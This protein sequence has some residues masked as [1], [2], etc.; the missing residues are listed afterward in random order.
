MFGS[1]FLDFLK[2]GTSFGCDSFILNSFIKSSKDD[3]VANIT[4][5]MAKTSLLLI[6]VSIF[7][8]SFESKVTR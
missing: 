4:L 3:S 1:I 6:L 7:I 8:A 5:S 2:T